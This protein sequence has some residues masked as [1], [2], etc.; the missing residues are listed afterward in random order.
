MVGA[1]R[2]CCYSDALRVSERA[3]ADMS[4]PGQASSIAVLNQ[5]N[6]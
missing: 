6:I 5:L 1:S 4:A 3:V 2:P